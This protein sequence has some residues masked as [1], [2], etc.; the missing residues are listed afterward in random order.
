MLKKSVLIMLTA[1]N[2]FFGCGEEPESNYV[3]PEQIE[4]DGSTNDRYLFRDIIEKEKKRDE[5]Y[6]K[7]EF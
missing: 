4:Y 6:K 3:D 5:R 2:L 1:L 7:D